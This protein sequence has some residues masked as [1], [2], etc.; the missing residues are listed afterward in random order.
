MK[1]I[2]LLLTAVLFFSFPDALA[3]TKALK[4]TIELKMP[5][6][7]DVDLPGTRGASVAWHPV[8]KKYYAVFAGNAGFP[9][10]VFDPAGKRLS[11]N[12]Q[13]AMI[14]T[15]GLWYDPISKKITGNGYDAAGWFNY[16]L[17]SKGL[18]TDI[19]SLIEEMRQPGPQCVGVYN[20]IDNQVLFLMGSQVFKYSNNGVVIDSVTIYWGRYKSEGIPETVDKYQSPED[21]NNTALVYTRITGKELGFLNANNRTIDLYDIKTGFKT[22]SLS[23]PENAPVESSFNFAFANG[24]YWLFDIENRKWIGYK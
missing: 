8:Q 22:T 2:L 16:K 21:Y 23:L 4:K 6:A 11:G 10:A 1:R 20:S 24:I 9:S 7:D 12:D 5:G 15:R 19:E 13:A 17:D 18:V 14:D 3:Q